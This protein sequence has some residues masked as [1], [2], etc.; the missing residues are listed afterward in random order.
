MLTILNSDSPNSVFGGG[1]SQQ[2]TFTSINATT[3]VD[4]TPREEKDDNHSI[5]SS[6]LS[7]SSTITAPTSPTITESQNP[8]SHAYNTESPSPKNKGSSESQELYQQ[9]NVLNSEQEVLQTYQIKSRSAQIQ[10]TDK[11]DTHVSEESVTEAQKQQA[12]SARLHFS[13]NFQT[14]QFTE[15]EDIVF[16]PLKKKNRK[17]MTKRE[18]IVDGEKRDVGNDCSSEDDFP[19]HIGDHVHK[20]PEENKQDESHAQLHNEKSY[21]GN[22]ITYEMFITYL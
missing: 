15:D 14:D 4:I 7:N 6:S 11:H 9:E 3:G 18:K 8:N 16:E 13:R 20:S 17:L 22:Y 10:N 21:E 19:V 5:A 2:S 12:L 1:K